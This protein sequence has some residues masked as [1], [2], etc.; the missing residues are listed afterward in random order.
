MGWRRLGLVLLACWWLWCAF[1]VASGIIE[2]HQLSQD[3]NFNPDLATRMMLDSSENSYTRDA[4]HDYLAAHANIKRAVFG[5]VVIP[6]L[7]GIAF[8][9]VRWIARGF[10]HQKSPDGGMGF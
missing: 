4:A 8:L 2:L 1:I 6:V 9:V 10:G 5:A 7:A 3:W